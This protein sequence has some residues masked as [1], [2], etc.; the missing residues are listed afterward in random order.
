MVQWLSRWTSDLKVGGSRLSPWDRIVSLDK[1]LY[2][3]LVSLHPG[4]WWHTAGGS[5]AMDEHPIQGE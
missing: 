1:K 2:P 4:Y 5:P 3:T